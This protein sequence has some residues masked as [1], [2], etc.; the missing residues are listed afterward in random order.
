M[1]L[2]I[3]IADGIQLAQAAQN[4]KWKP[5]EPKVIS[6]WHP[7]SVLDPQCPDAPNSFLDWLRNMTPTAKR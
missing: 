4:A 5:S 3:P 1:R 2:G 7:R 6:A